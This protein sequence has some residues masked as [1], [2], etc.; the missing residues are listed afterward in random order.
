MA[1]QAL[2][3][4]W[5]PNKGA[6]ETNFPRPRPALSRPAPRTGRGHQ[7]LSHKCTCVC[8]LIEGHAD[9]EREAESE[10]KRDVSLEQAER[11]QGRALNHLVPGVAA[12]PGYSETAW[13]RESW[14][15]CCPEPPKTGRPAQAST[16][17]G[18]LYRRTSQ[19]Q[20]LA[21][22]I[23]LGSA[24]A[25]G[26]YPRLCRWGQSPEGRGER[27]EGPRSRLEQPMQTP[28]FGDCCHHVAQVL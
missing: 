13:K 23:V 6:P 18:S 4:A 3:G 12:A 7:L 28:S 26:N 9:K 14:P 17:P 1:H 20:G 2:T 22:T 25:P 21:H 10:E 24:L 27:K 19:N 8:S 15:F 16:S 5:K 11:R